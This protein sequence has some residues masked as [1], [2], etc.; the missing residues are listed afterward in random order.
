MRRFGVILILLFA[1]FGVLSC[2]EAN[3][4]SI[5]QGVSTSRPKS[6]K[7][8]RQAEVAYS[9]NA[10]EG[11]SQVD[12]V[13]LSAN[14][15]LHIVSANTNQESDEFLSSATIRNSDSDYD[16]LGLIR[17][18][19]MLAG[20]D[21][22]SPAIV[23]QTVEN[24]IRSVAHYYL[25]DLKSVA[26]FDPAGIDVTELEFSDSAKN[27]KFISKSLVNSSHLIMYRSLNAGE[28]GKFA[29]HIGMWDVADGKL[30]FVSIRDF[31]SDKEFYNFWED[32]DEV[33]AIVLYSTAGDE[34][35]Q[36]QQYYAMRFSSDSAQPVLDEKLNDLRIR[37]FIVYS[38]GTFMGLTQ[39]GNILHSG[40]DRTNHYTLDSSFSYNRYTVP[41]V[42][43]NEG[44]DSPAVTI[45]ARY[46][47]NGFIINCYNKTPADNKI[48]NSTDDYVGHI[49]TAGFAEAF[50]S[51][52]I[53]E[54]YPVVIKSG[55]QKRYKVLVLSTENGLSTY[56][57]DSI[58]PK[59]MRTNGQDRS[60]RIALFG[61]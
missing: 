10:A 51:E 20:Y 18:V 26:D 30:D 6:S 53:S 15:G 17:N 50:R 2:N 37:T 61:I 22:S 12:F 44:S 8:W 31:E 41:A 19:Y 58:K 7:T 5:M 49:Q 32:S 14:D 29:Y 47:G 11:D 9:T 39:S 16:I 40:V 54:I 24:K 46:N 52:E 38:D 45:F 1:A 57:F 4:I 3:S 33:N 23:V 34:D 21:S 27:F 28:G 13:F 56:A 59:E 43:R 25:V 48:Y 55:T 36:K 60:N 35:I 42:F